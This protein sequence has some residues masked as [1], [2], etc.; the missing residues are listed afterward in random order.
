MG[1]F[2]RVEPLAGDQLGKCS[3]RG[4]K[5]LVASILDDPSPVQ[6]DDP[7]ALSDGGQPVGNDDTGTAEPVQ[8]LGYHFLRDVVKRAGSL[9]QDEQL[10]PRRNG[11]RDEEPTVVP[12]SR[13]RSEKTS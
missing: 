13:P 8:S 5:F 2:L 6:N 3:A 10:R 11:P 7:V 9:V 1:S 12:L 4:Q